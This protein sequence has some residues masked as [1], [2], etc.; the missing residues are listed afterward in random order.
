MKKLKIAELSVIATTLLC[1]FFTAGYFIGRGAAVQVVSFEK[2]SPSHASASAEAS[3]RPIT[4]DDAGSFEDTAAV[5]SIAVT[6]PE[7]SPA[8]VSDTASPAA[9]VQ[10]DT[11]KININTASLTKLDELPG[12]GPVLSQSII[13]YR[14]KNGSFK[15]IEQIMDVD[16]IGEKKYAAMKDM[17]TVG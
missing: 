6:D 5:P 9:A 15:S 4:E 2:L 12:I 7:A 3:V 11:D 14:D 16:G 1:L 13:D 8:L 17:I 10:P